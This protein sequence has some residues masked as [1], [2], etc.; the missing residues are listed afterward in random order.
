MSW[1]SWRSLMEGG[2]EQ[3][4]D[5]EYDVVRVTNAIMAKVSPLM[6]STTLQHPLVLFT[7]LML[8]FVFFIRVGID[9]QVVDVNLHD[10]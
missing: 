8:M 7:K 3:K 6:S 1:L 2:S 5:E 10:A 9:H 4:V